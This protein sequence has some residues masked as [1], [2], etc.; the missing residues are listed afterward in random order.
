MSEGVQSEKG[1]YRDGDAAIVHLL[2]PTD[3]DT[4]KVILHGQSIGG[5]VAID[6]VSA[7]ESRSL[8]F[9]LGSSRSYGR[10]YF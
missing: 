4:S 5:A 9:L 7:H 3:I 2:A 10:V 6:L 1:F 8:M